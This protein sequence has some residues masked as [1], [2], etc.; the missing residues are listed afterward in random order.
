MI[1]LIILLHLLCVY[2]VHVLVYAYVVVAE[3]CSDA[4]VM[5]GEAGEVAEF[6]GF[7]ERDLGEVIVFWIFGSYEFFEF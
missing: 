2:V 6:E 4:G 5:G 7:F 1:L 3:G